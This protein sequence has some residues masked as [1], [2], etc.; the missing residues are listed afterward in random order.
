MVAD[1][2]GEEGMTNLEYIQSLS[3]EDFIRW[4][5][6]PEDGTEP[7]PRKKTLDSMATSSSGCM[8]EWLM[9][10][11]TEGYLGLSK[12]SNVIY[13]VYPPFGEGGTGDAP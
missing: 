5:Y 9:E 7:S 12:D 10:E 3:I 4:L 2:E 1:A 8:R 13:G 11:H 6:Y